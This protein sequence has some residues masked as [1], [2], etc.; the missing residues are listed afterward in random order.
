[1]NPS[2]DV[3]VIG[4]GSA[5]CFAAI[6]AARMGARVL[7]IEKNGILGGT[8]TA[9]RVNFPGL[10]HA[11]GKQIIDGPAWESILRCVQKGGAT[12]PDFPYKSEHHNRQQILL[13][14]FTYTCVLDEM[15]AE[16]GVSLLFHSMVASVTETKDA[17]RLQI[18]TKE[19]LKEISASI[20][21]DATGDADAIRMAGYP[22]KQSD[23][24]QPATL[25]NDLDGYDADVI[26]YEALSQ[27]LEDAYEKGTLRKEDSQGRDITR[28]VRKKR[29]HMHVDAPN[30]HTSEGKTELELKARATLGRILSCLSEFDGL[31]SIR[32]ARFGAECGVRETVRI[33]GEHEI[34]AEEYLS[35]RIERD[36]VCH[37]FYP[38]DLH[39]PLGI[40][41]IFL[42]DGV[43]PTVPLGALI[44]KHAARILAAGRCLSSD[45]DANSALRVQATCMATGQVA[46]VAAALS[47]RNGKAVTEISLPELKDALR[48]LGAIVP[49]DVTFA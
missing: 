49:G 19:G 14:I 12:L 46:G 35:G 27:F 37:G 26:D 44:P 21:I 11:W 31:H 18:A 24:L 39:Q 10:F 36:S 38:I 30:A 6:S 43:V 48:A 2:V 9:G 1:M 3:A 5:G 28:M 22:T 16:A 47:A 29:I 7:L 40:K 25:I 15:C 8:T 23:R 34:T 33:V 42:E 45:T 17:V 20:L 4:G 13:D 32:V 41:Q